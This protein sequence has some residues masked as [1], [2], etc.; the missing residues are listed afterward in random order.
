M[1]AM[2]LFNVIAG[3]ASIISLIISVVVL[4]KVT[5]IESQTIKNVNNSTINQARGDIK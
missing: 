1:S 4:N 3:A 5:K 2:D